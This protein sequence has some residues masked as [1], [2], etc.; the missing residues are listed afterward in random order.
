MTIIS[1]LKKRGFTLIELMIVVVIIGILAALAIYGV[2]KYVANSK[3]AEARMMLGHM[4]KDVLIRF[5]GE[6]QVA[7][8]LALGGTAGVAQ[9]LCDSAS[10][11]VPTG[12]STLIARNKYQPAPSEWK[13]DGDNV[14]WACLDTEILTPIYFMYSYIASLTAVGAPIAGD[15]FITRANGDLDGDGLLSAFELPGEILDESDELVLILATTVSESQ[16]EE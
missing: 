11:T 3:S 5:E 10:N 2:K 7:K 9:I 1:K 13:T 14:G 15:S 12:G 8:I 16:P 4:S 6:S